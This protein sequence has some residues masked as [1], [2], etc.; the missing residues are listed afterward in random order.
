VFRWPVDVLRLPDG[1]PQFF[2]ERRFDS[3]GAS[4]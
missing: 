3:P 2:P 4:A 1:T